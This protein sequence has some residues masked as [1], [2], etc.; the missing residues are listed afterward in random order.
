MSKNFNRRDFFKISSVGMATMLS[1]SLFAQTN[2]NHSN[3]GVA[4]AKE[5]RL[6]FVSSNMARAKVFFM[7]NDGFETLKAACE[8]IYPKDI[9]LKTP[10]AIELGIAYFIDR[11]LAGEYGNHTRE[12]MNPPFF[13]GL[14]TQGYQSPI[15]RNE[16]FKIGLK[17]LDDEAKKKFG[18]SFHK[19]S[20]KQQDEILTMCEKSE[21][22]LKGI[23]SSYFFSLLLELT[24]AGA[25]SDPVYGGNDNKNGWRN[26]Q[27]PGPVMSW[28]TEIN[29]KEFKNLEPISLG[30]MQDM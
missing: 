27:Y 20:P 8:R 1:S 24:F 21:I 13:E 2:H 16:V 17:G 5:N 25:Y 9:E 7:V 10:G 15:K 19:I 6:K 18:D 23:S 28:Y 14:P 26:I 12:Y 22:K 4:L 29:E 30:D 3:H 11:Q